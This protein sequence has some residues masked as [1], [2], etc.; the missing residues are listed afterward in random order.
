MHGLSMIP[1]LLTWPKRIA[2]GRIRVHLV[3]EGQPGTKGRPRF[4]SRTGQ[5][6]TPQKTADT[7]QAM[8][9]QI[10]ASHQALILDESTAF[11]V[12]LLFAITSRQRKDID[13]MV[14]LVFDACTGIVW[15]D[16]S[17]VIELIAHV[18]KDSERPL[19]E[20]VIYS[21]G[22]T[23]MPSILCGV[24]GKR[25]RVYPSWKAR[26][27][28]S[29]A[30]VSLA[31]KKTGNPTVKGH[32]VSC[33]VCGKVVYRNAYQ[34]RVNK[35]SRFFCSLDCRHKGM[36]DLLV[37]DDCG[38]EFRRAKSLNRSGKHYCS[39]IC[40]ANYARKRRAKNAKGICSICGGPTT[41]KK[42]VRCQGCAIASGS[43]RFQGKAPRVDVVA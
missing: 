6:Y 25:F 42:Y 33:S 10:K 20:L 15:A 4:N 39:E 36:T 9:W 2:Q 19:T 22:V 43:F 35:A 21:L 13:N 26:K 11:G 14:K 1:N 17:Q 7:E 31:K 3:L 34:I 28:C 37:C 18:V 41:K 12:R 5:V 40:A 38:T 30:C 29:R 24:C 23:D 27:Y 32:P 16:D 8:A